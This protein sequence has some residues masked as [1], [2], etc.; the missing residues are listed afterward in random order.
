MASSTLD[1]LQRTGITTTL[2]CVL[3]SSQPETHDHLFFQ[4]N[5]NKKVWS[6]VK[7]HAFIRWPVTTWPNLINW[8]CAVF[9]GKKDP[10]SHIAKTLLSTTIYYLW[11]ERNNKTFKNTCNSHQ[12]LTKDIIQCI[13]LHL[14]SDNS[15]AILDNSI[16]MRWS[17]PLM[18]DQAPERSCHRPS[19]M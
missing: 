7:N 3:C 5:F 6:A 13:G 8:V 17:I 12:Q 1:R 15:G 2:T 14:L 19:S 11:Y 9:K 4:C 10:Q 16:R 18:L